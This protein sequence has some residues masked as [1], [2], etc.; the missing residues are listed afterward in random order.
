MLNLSMKFAPGS[1]HANG[2]LYHP[3]HG[4]I[5]KG[6]LPTGMLLSFRL[7]KE[8]AWNVLIAPQVKD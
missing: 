3:G 6:P 4:L 7:M 1:S 2:R 5:S 8:G